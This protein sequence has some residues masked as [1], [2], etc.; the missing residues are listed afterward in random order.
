MQEYIIP[1]VSLLLEMAP[2]L[3]LG[4]L[5]AGLL[6]AFVPPSFFSRHLSGSG[7]RPVVNSALMGVPLPLCSCGVIPTAMGLRKSGASRGATVSFLIST[8]QTG[9]D[10]ILAT[11][12]T[13]G[14][15]M[16]L[17]RPVIAFVT[18]IFGGS[19][20]SRFCP[21]PAQATSVAAV[22]DERRHGFW[23]RIADALHYGFVDMMQDVGKWLTIGLVLAGII[24]VAVPD[25][26]LTGLRDYPLL[27][28]LLILVVAVPM[29]VCA[30]GSIPVAMALMLKG[31]SPGAALVFLMAGPATN[32][33]AMIV[34]GKALDRR[35]MVLYTL[36]IVLGAIVF[37]LVIDY[38][39]PASWFALSSAHDAC[40]E[41][42]AFPWWKILSAVIFVILLINAMLH[43]H[44]HHHET[45]VPD[46]GAACFIVKG[47]QCN[48][49]KASVERT[50]GAI[51]GVTSVD[52]SLADGTV[53]VSGNV[54]PATVVE[55]VEGLGF[56][57]SPADD[58]H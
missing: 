58:R 35:A 16:A 38:L 33:A 46:S 43:K 3:L 26:F 32:A 19:L 36:S 49:C 1:F 4:F 13:M 21:E 40:C 51:D 18:A 50:V 28:M 55:Q 53:T 2:Y 41:M 11:A 8:P 23:A 25:G 34:I 7:F 14:L 10:S 52:V 54:D 30:T 20:V 39:L 15:P 48:H 17:M 9:V 6:H 24:A 12:A 22:A 27:N 29:Y 37:G 44:Q 56:N 5:V 31:L 42:D 45:S 57:C 47:M